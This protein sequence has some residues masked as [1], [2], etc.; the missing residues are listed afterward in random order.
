MPAVSQWKGFVS[1]VPALKARAYNK[2]AA[3][4][5]EFLSRSNR[6]EAWNGELQSELVE[7]ASYFCEAFQ[8]EAAAKHLEKLKISEESKTL[9]RVLLETFALY[10]I[11]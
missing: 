9:L 2:I 1:I 11:L 6:D 5:R 3:T 7:S 10:L 8:F 4:C